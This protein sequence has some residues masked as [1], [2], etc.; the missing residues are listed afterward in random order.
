ME[1][2]LIPPKDQHPQHGMDL[3]VLTLAQSLALG[4]YW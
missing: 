3:Y 2:R 1:V 4:P